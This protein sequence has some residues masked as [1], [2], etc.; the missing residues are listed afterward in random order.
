MIYSNACAYAIR[1]LA[2]LALLR[3]DGYVLLDELC[4]G[5][6]LPRHFV[7]KIFQDLV[8]RGILLSAKGRGGGFALA[9]KPSQISLLDIVE[10]V[11]GIEELDHCVVGMTRCDDFQPCPQHEQW[12]ALRQQFRKFFTETSLEK[13]SKTLSKK[14]DILGEPVPALKGRSKPVKNAR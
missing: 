1:A 11:D 14:L 7:A 5:T 10:C 4:E 6:D 3:P 2:R 12:K 8:R 9:R 13:M